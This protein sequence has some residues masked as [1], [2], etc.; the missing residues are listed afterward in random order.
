M[1]E[2]HVNVRAERGKGIRDAFSAGCAPFD[3]VGDPEGSGFG[4]KGVL[5][6][7]IGAVYCE[8][9]LRDATYALETL[10]REIEYRTCRRG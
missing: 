4:K 8:Y 7:V 5:S 10:E 1:D 3:H 2:H 9:H 6:G